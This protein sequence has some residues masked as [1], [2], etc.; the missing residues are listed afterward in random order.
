MDDHKIGFL[1]FPELLLSCIAV[2][3][4]GC[5]YEGFKVLRESLARKSAKSNKVVITPATSNGK[6]ADSTT[7]MIEQ[8]VPA[9]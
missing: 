2:A 4:M 1:L 5:L 6:M 8:D 7:M 9:W 3:V